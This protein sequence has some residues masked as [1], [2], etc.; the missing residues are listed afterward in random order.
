MLRVLFVLLSYLT[1]FVALVGIFPACT[2]VVNK[3]KQLYTPSDSMLIS[4]PAISGKISTEYYVDG[5]CH[6]KTTDIQF[7]FDGGT[8]WQ[9]AAESILVNDFQLNCQSNKEFSFKINLSAFIGSSILLRGQTTAGY[10]NIISK[11]ITIDNT[12]PSGSLTAEGGTT[13]I[14][15]QNTVFYYQTSDVDVFKIYITDQASCLSG[16]QWQ[17]LD[18]LKLPWTFTGTGPQT[19]FY[20]TMDFARNE[21]TCDSVTIDVNSTISAPTSLSLIYPLN[22]ISNEVTPTIRVDGVNAGD[23]VFLYTAADCNAS[24]LVASG[25]SANTSITLN[26]SITGV[27]GSYV[28]FAKRRNGYGADSACSIANTTYQLD[29]LPPANPSIAIADSPTIINTQ[30]VDLELFADGSPA[31]MYITNNSDCSSGGVWTPYSDTFLAWGLT[32]GDGSKAVKVK[33]RDVAGNISS[34]STAVV[35]LDT[36]APQITGLS[37]QVTPVTSHT[38]SWSCDEAPCTYEFI[39]DTETNTVLQD[40]DFS[41]IQSY[42]IENGSPDAFYYLHIR[43]KDL[44][45]NISATARYLAVVGNFPNTPTSLSLVSPTS[46]TSNITT[47]TISVAGI[48]AG[49][50]ITLHTTEDCSDVAIASGTAG[51]SSINLIPTL[52]TDQTYK[53]YAKAFNGSNYSSCSLAS[54]TYTLDRLAPTSPTGLTDGYFALSTYSPFLSWTESTDT[55]SGVAKYEIQLETV[56]PS[57]VIIAW[58][59][60]GTTT[61]FTYSGLSLNANVSYRVRLRAVDQ[62]GNQSST[63]V[64]DGWVAKAPDTLSGPLCF[65]SS[66]LSPGRVETA[67]V[68]GNVA[69]LGGSFTSVGPCHG[70]LVLLDNEGNYVSTYSLAGAV[71]GMTADNVGGVFI[72]GDFAFSQGG[73][74]TKNII[75]IKSDR[76]VDTSFNLNINGSIS[77]AL[78]VDEMLYLAGNFT[79][80]NGASRSGLASIDIQF[81]SAPTL[82]P[83]AATGISNSGIGGFY[84][85][86]IFDELYLFG[87]F[88]SFSG[89]SSRKYVVRFSDANT[90]NPALDSTWLPN[91]NGSIASV[92]SLSGTLFFGGSFNQING[93]A[94]KYI[95]KM[96]RSTGAFTAVGNNFYSGSST[97]YYITNLWVKNGELFAS[98]Y[99]STAR[100]NL[101][102]L[103]TQTAINSLPIS[104]KHFLGNKSSTSVFIKTDNGIKELNTPP[105]GSLTLNSYNLPTWA[106][107]PTAIHAIDSNYYLLGGSFTT[108]GAVRSR[109]N[110]AAID[111]SNGSLLPWQPEASSIVYKI[112]KH[113]TSIYAGGSFTS[114]SGIVNNYVAKIDKTNGNV[115]PSEANTDAAV[116]DMAIFSNNLV[117]AGSFNGIN[118]T[119]R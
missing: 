119:S 59:D 29:R 101:S 56:S 39:V 21:S 114:V 43:A 109:A 111:I 3:V 28:F 64:S 78:A 107:T 46:A 13:T 23:F 48:T 27:D 60:I 16:G 47:P 95:T 17:T 105:G 82:T 79:N 30:F 72:Y 63:T 106:G 85:E 1:S 81:P 20:K 67:V 50:T 93:A 66:A 102:T 49:E 75:R 6:K 70:G 51:G 97:T 92:T 34:C 73:Y 80:I 54:L 35:S 40:S 37:N 19:V 12:P 18:N 103:A 9:S 88:T 38:W 4:A 99:R 15:N 113:G 32:A 53:F 115:L 77:S 104:T 57:N 94:S 108:V 68:D 10:S 117:L 86:E 76:T 8:N 36:K 61:S 62:A 2:P 24:A 55:L 14:S 5:K 100:L 118:N 26:A 84:Y 69:Y 96:D 98:F 25:V 110:L 7:S 89:S 91:F 22:S 31:E 58:Q 87:S 83:F 116:S 42:T 44:A 52:N 45:G 90:P 65:I 74:S 71:N 11:N 33:F 112:V 41:S